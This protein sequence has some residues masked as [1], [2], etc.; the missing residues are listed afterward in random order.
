MNGRKGS[1][2]WMDGWKKGVIY[3]WMEERSIRWRKG[4]VDGE[5][6]L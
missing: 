2:R 4:V 6:E 5:K 1:D 3:G